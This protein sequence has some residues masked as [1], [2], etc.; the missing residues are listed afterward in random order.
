MVAVCCTWPSVC[1]C[2]SK[3]AASRKETADEKTI[4]AT[5]TDTTGAADTAGNTEA[6]RR[7]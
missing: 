1:Y 6:V 4:I 3:A 5:A 7:K 2:R